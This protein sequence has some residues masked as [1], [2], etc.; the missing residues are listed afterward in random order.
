M[1]LSLTYCKAMAF[2]KSQPLRTRAIHRIGTALFASLLLA[3]LTVNAVAVIEATTSN[4]VGAFFNGG[5]RGEVRGTFSSG[6][7][8][9]SHQF[10]AR[11]KYSR[12]LLTT[13]TPGSLNFRYTF[14]S[15]HI[16]DGVNTRW[17]RFDGRPVVIPLRLVW[18]AF[19]FNLLLFTLLFLVPTLYFALRPIR[20][21]YRQ[22]RSHC[23]SCNYDLRGLTTT[24]PTCPE[25]GRPVAAH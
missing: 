22:L 20:C 15:W 8:L 24:F 17:Q 18:T 1:V 2:F 7:P 16:D 4:H 12:Q 13:D 3:C 21:A 10:D 11:G 5:T 9:K 25:C 23:P 6:W 14:D 19:V